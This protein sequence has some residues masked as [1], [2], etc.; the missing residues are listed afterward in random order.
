MTLGLNE[1][2]P[3]FPGSD[4]KRISYE[5]LLPPFLGRLG[6]LLIDMLDASIN[7][8]AIGNLP[9]FDLHAA[10]SGNQI[11][12]STLLKA[13]FRGSK[14]ALKLSVPEGNARS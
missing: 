7:L 3:G 9:R 12:T 10:G 5:T 13:A 4:E 11:L 14:L 6:G 8:R 1:K 2:E